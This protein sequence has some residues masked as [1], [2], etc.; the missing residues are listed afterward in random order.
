MEYTKRRRYTVNVETHDLQEIYQH[1]LQ[2][3]DF[4]PTGEIP[5]VEFQQLGM[6]RLKLLQH[7]ENH[8]VRTDFKTLHDRK[9]NLSTA[10][11]KDGLKYFVHL[12]YA[13]GCKSTTEVDLQYRKK[14]HLS[15]FIMRLSYCQD[16]EHLM[17][18]INQEV[19]LFKLRFNSLDKDGIEK[20]LS[21]HNIECQQITPEER[22]EI[23]EELYS[24]TPK[25]VNIELS[26]FY[27]VP[28]RKVTDLVRSRR[29]YITEGMAY[30]AQADLVSLFVSHFRANL[31]DSLEY[32][33]NY[34]SN[35]SDD[36]R[37][38]SFLKSLPGSFS[39]MTRVVWTSTSTPID[40][41]DE[42]SRTSYPLCMRS[43]HEALRTQHH[44]KNSARIQYN[45]FIKGIGVTLEDALRFWKIELTKKIDPDKFDK[46]YAYSVR[47]MF[48]KEGKQTN[49]TPLGC[50]K[51]I[52]SAVGPGE[53]HGCPYK[54][55]DHESLRQ[56]LFGYGIPAESVNEIAELSKDGHY[57]IACTTYFKVLHNRLPDRAITHPNGYFV[58]SRAIL[59]KDD[60][61]ESDS[62]E[63][64]TQSGRTSERFSNTPRM[65]KSMGTPLRNVDRSI[66]GT[67]PRSIN[68]SNTP[69][70]KVERVSVTPVRATKATPKRIDTN[71]NEDEIAELMSEDM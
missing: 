53:Y 23:R 56:K 42:L 17:W 1:D 34:V 50:P 54:H 39:G 58:E 37:L 52:S 44:L 2:M 28:F 60:P 51:I 13:K 14:D 6:E 46:Q 18:F 62:Q 65:D 66:L 49:Y 32:T 3:Y 33:K 63:R 70:R 30:I 10:L 64:F 48:G 68:K 55:M 61:T 26:E 67:P 27:K 22:H 35:I 71:L 19:E 24:S 29:V 15:H 7:I 4:P 45:L 59:A 57:L 25:L 38:I 12:L 9:Q 16:Q 31:H 8:A 36:E 11:E 69:V 47:H 20:L 40:K 21:I 41:L 43:L 5:F